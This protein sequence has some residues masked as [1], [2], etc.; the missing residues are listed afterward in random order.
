MSANLCFTY[1]F[2]FLLSFLPPNLRA[3]WTELDQNRLHE[4]FCAQW[5]RQAWG[6]GARAPWS[7]RMHANFA[8]L[9]PD[10]FHFWMTL[11]PRTSEPVHHAPVP[12]LPWIKILATPLFVLIL[13]GGGS[14]LLWRHCDMLCTSGFMDDVT[15]GHDGPYS[16]AWKA[17]PLI[18]Y[19]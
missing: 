1:V 6:T 12:P 19:H 7:L 13:C 3:S 15:F 2:F 5:R 14:V 9:T 18:Y 8:D 17:E 10:C 4:I 16:D 11:S